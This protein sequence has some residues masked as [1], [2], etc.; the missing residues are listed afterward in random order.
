[1]GKI[2]NWRE[3]LSSERELV[4]Y[5]A[6][7]IL[8]EASASRF[9]EILHA[10]LNWPALVAFAHE[11]HVETFLFE[12]LIL[13]GQE[14]V[15]G[16]WLERLRDS[17][18]KTAALAVLLSSELLRIH[19]IFEK[20]GV[21]LV[22]YKGPVLSWL[23]YGALTQRRFTDLDFFVPQK[24]ISRA[25]ALLKSA[26][27]IS[28][29]EIP[30]ETVGHPGDIPGQYAFFREATRTQVELHTER[31]LRY[32]PVPLNFEEM[33]RRLIPVE[34]C[35]RTL[36]TFS[37]EDTLV[38]LCVHGAKHFWDRLLWILDVAQLIK[39]H[40]VDWALLEKLAAKME[41]T[42]VVLFGLSLAHE[43]FEAPLPGRLLEEMR[44][45]PAIRKMAGKVYEG[46]A[47]VSDSATGVIPRAVFR[48][49]MR[50]G[51]GRGLRHTLRLALSPTESDRENVRLPRW[52]SPLHM[53]VRPFRLLR[54]YG[55]GLKRR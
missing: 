25:G 5:G 11:H 21:P 32:F 42:R 8:G 31:T 36:R 3:R 43:L 16:P 2:P 24:N 20:E 55:S 52:L 41:S 46:Y 23:A 51:I 28:K 1:M 39:A 50:D 17:A 27:F 6:R 30:T 37:I 12:N 9:L 53:L 35:G 44:R 18:R 38:M 45:D 13:T 54:E 26:G 29:I 33:S 19:E 7:P 48:V 22:P 47:G 49:R 15:P 34:L 14:N 40:A 4:L 10:P